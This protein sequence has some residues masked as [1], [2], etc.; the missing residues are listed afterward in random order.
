MLGASLAVKIHHPPINS[1]AELISSNHPVIIMNG[2]SIYK[3]ECTFPEKLINE[4]SICRGMLQILFRRGGGNSG[5][6][7]VRG[8][9]RQL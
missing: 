1:V 8:Q 2:T 5:A 7:T 4:G 3:Y 9:N 6:A